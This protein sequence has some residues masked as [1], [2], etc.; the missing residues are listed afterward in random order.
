MSRIVATAVALVSPSATVLYDQ[1]CHA[2]AAAY[3]IDE[4]KDIRDKMLAM[5]TYAQQA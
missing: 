1:M 2:I 5:E 3:A 4:V